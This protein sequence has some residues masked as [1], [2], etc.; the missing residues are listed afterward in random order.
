MKTFLLFLTV[1]FSFVLSSCGINESMDAVKATPEKMDN[2]QNTIGKMHGT[3]E[4]MNK[5][6]GETVAGVNDQ[7]ILIPLI[8]LMKYE[9]YD[10]LSPLP[11]KLLPYGKSLAQ[12]VTADQMVEIVY[13][14]LKEIDEVYPPKALDKNGNEIEYTAEQID[15]INTTKLGRLAALQITAGFLP[16]TTVDQIIENQIINFGRFEE[17]TYTILMLRV[18]FIRDVLL[19]ASLLSKPLNSVGGLNQAIA[20]TQSLELITQLAFAAKIKMKVSG[21]LAPQENFEETLKKDLAL[22]K[23]KKIKLSAEKDLKLELQVITGNPEKDAQ[24]LKSKQEAFALAMKT[25]DEHI[26][27]LQ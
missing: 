10:E 24:I 22:T 2:M 25:V 13:L 18:Q 9:N 21:L 20:F 17:T 1:C 11:V 3:M 5:G 19:D 27:K 23:W 8:E 4:K 12:A 14:W 15:K 7:R 6:M 16:Q 26:Q